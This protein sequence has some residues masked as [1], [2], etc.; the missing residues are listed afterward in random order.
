MSNWKKWW[1]CWMYVRLRECG[2]NWLISNYYV[3]FEQEGKL[4]FIFSDEMHFPW[5]M[6]KTVL[7][8]ICMGKTDGDHCIM[9]WT[10]PKG[11]YF[12]CIE[13]E[14]NF[15]RV[16]RRKEG[17]RESRLAFLA[18]IVYTFYV[19]ITI[20]R[21]SNYSYSHWI[22]FFFFSWNCCIHVIDN[23]MILP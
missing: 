17:E 14:C 12:F 5:S 16:E 18:Q 20:F 23:Q 8:C 9:A 11:I 2:S 21:C 7:Q 13:V 1:F 15:L 3:L 22:E 10:G 4:I 19:R 6:S